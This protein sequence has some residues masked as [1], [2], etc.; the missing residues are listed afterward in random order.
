LV[1][2]GLFTILAGIALTACG[3]KDFP[4]NPPP[5]V[6]IEV[7]ARVDSH[8]VQVSPNVFGAGPVNFTVANMSRSPIRFT[9]TGPKE[10][11]TAEIQ[12]GAPDYLKMDLTEGSYQVTAGNSKIKPATIK[13]GSSRPSAQ[14]KLLLP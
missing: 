9:V 2:L 11:S 14:N 8:Q 1:A 3:A 12:P 4:N 10:G 13:V 7:S 5:P 6:Q